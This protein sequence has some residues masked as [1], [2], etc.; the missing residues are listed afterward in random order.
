MMRIDTVIKRLRSNYERARKN[1][2]IIKRPI[3]WALYQ[4]WRWANEYE[5]PKEDENNAYNGLS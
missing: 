4:T 1:K 3:S 5:I 2:N